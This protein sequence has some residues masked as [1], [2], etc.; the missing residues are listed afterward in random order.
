MC[1]NECPGM[2][3]CHGKEFEKLYEKYEEEGRGRT[4]IK[5][6]KLWFAVL[7]SQVETGTPYMLFKD[8]CNNKSNQQVRGSEMKMKMK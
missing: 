1:P 4:T 8:H 7:E 3:D 6:Q 2:V 5:A